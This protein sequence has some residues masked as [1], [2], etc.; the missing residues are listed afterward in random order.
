M[1]PSDSDVLQR[2]KAEW[3]SLQPLS[4]GNNDRLWK[5]LR[6]EWDF[7]SNHI[8]GNTLTYGET[9]LL[10][11]H[12]ET[13]GTHTIREYEEM[14]AHDVAIG[15]VRQLAWE[16]RGLTEADVRGLNQLLLKEPF[17][18]P[19][20]T[21]DGAPTRKQIVPGQYKTQPNNVRTA[22]GEMFYFVDPLDVPQRMYEHL[23]LVNA[24]PPSGADLP[25]HLAKIHHGFLM[26]HPFDDGNGRVG[27]LLL[28]YVLLRHGWLP[29]IIRTDEK[30]VYLSALHRADT[31]ERDY[32]ELA[33]FLGAGLRSSLELGIKAARGAL[34]S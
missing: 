17:W 18:S 4:P 6:L 19:A 27:R 8:E 10:L 1:N 20:L 32:S 29:I 22:T 5:K 24:E 26:I 7:H 30:R 34:P 28:N 15:Q 31:E 25:F 13:R 12:G 9:E 14:K 33:S 23:R 11:L 16:K 2:L 3:D 21:P